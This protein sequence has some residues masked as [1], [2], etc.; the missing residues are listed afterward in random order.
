MTELS[1]SAFEA[2]EEF[3]CKVYEPQTHIMCVRFGVSHTVVLTAWKL[4]FLSVYNRFQCEF[5]N[6]AYWSCS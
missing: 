1:D 4:Q 5:F 6:S 3:V 2:I